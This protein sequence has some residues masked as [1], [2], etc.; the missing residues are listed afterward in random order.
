MAIV[1]RR[2][3][4][5]PHGDRRYC[6]VGPRMGVDFHVSGVGGFDECAGLECHYKQQPSYLANQ[7][8]FS[9]QCW[10]TGGRCWG[11]GTSLYATEYLLPLFREMG[12]EDFWPV[13]EQEHD[14]RDVDAFG[15][16]PSDNAV[17]PH[18]ADPGT[19]TTRATSSSSSFSSHLPGPPQDAT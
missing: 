8:P 19:L 11:D 18:A 7:E 14:R 17:D 15:D 13:L 5:L 6:V 4:D 16:P 12:V 9:E 3:V 10:L 2:I 1:E